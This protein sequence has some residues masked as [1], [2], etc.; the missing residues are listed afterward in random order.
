MLMY[1][2]TTQLT[3]RGRQ[4]TSAHYSQLAAVLDIQNEVSADVLI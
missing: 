1:S 3:I 4:S 2:P